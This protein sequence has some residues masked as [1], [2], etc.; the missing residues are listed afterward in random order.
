MYKY[1]LYFLIFSFLGWCVEV[2]FYF[3]KTGRFVNRGLAKGPVCPIYGIGICLSYL[4]LKDIDSF[5][6][7][8]L[9]SMAVATAVELAVGYL[10]YRMLGKRLWDYSCERGNILGH[11]CPRFSLIWG[12]VCAAVIRIIPRLDPAVSYLEAPLWCGISFVFFVILVLD[13][14]HEMRTKDVLN[15]I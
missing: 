5:I 2:V 14:K 9:F 7:L 8:S 11:V 13:V 4:L 6:L 1:L 15:N 3:F 12:V 10:T